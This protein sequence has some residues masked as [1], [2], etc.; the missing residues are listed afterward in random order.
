MKPITLPSQD[1]LHYLFYY[2]EKTG[3]FYARFKAPNRKIGQRGTGKGSGYLMW[4]VDGVR[5]LEQRLIWMYVYGEDPGSLEVDHKDR[6]KS[7]NKIENLRL[8]TRSQ[9][10]SNIRF[11][12]VTWSKDTNKWQAQIQVNSKKIHLGL[13]TEEQDAINAYQ[14]AKKRL[15]GE[16]APSTTHTN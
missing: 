2:N 4:S 7:N 1:K 9:N 6:D 8:A 11:R 5:F 16:F 3:A 15:H 12:G 13:F 14:E 10:Q